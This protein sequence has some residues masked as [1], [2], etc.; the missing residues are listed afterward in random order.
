MS[1]NNNASDKKEWIKNVIS[2]AI[3][4]CKLS[5]ISNHYLI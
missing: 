2:I 1:N 3:D 5:T 4:F